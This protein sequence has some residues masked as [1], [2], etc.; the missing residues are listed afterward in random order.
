MV[1]PS[2]R[3]DRA[4]SMIG[5]ADDL[6]ALIDDWRA[7]LANERRVSQNTFQAYQSD[8]FGFL[9]FLAEHIGDTPSA[10]N[11]SALR[12]ADFRS[13]LAK[14]SLEGLERRSTARALSVVR[15]F[16][17]WCERNGHLTNHAIRSVRSPKVPHTLPRPLSSPDAMAIVEQ[18]GDLA[19]APWI[20]LRDIALF[21][22]L[23]GCG[24]RISE[25]LGL[26]R[27][28]APDG[29]ILTVMGKGSKE[30]MVPVLPAVRDAI[31][32][33]VEVCPFVLD[34]NKSLFRGA[35]GGPLNPAVA[36]R[37]MRV[38]RGWLGL[39]D[40]ATP[41]ALRHSFATHLLAGGGDLRSIQELLGHASLSTTQ[42][43][44]EIE[45]ARLLAEYRAAHPRAR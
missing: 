29:D 15:G 40:T 9:R 25:A 12:P 11:V 5:V 27:S 34:P 30:R 45:D 38:V 7:W 24:L 8:L 43:Y 23:Y 6:A 32:A 33:Y 19:E 1:D 37:S 14:R 35:R 41:H 21:T 28:D 22:L 4:E 39:P 26:N 10:A 36:Q 44:T 18:I 3:I 17:R 20:G 13:W 42:R 2:Q 31:N 16:F